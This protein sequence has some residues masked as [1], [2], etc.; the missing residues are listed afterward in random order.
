MITT[1]LIQSGPLRRAF[2]TSLIRQNVENKSTRE[3]DV[4]VRDW[5]S[6][7]TTTVSPRDQTDMID[8]SRLQLLD[9]TLPPFDNNVS[10]I[11][12]PPEPGTP[13][14]PGT[15]LTF[16]PPLVRT[17]DLFPD[18]TDTTYSSPAPFHRRMWA[19]G[20]FAFDPGNQLKFGQVIS[21]KST[22][23]DVQLK[24]WEKTREA[25]QV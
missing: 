18:G 15:E 5:I 6:K 4:R 9:L 1:R 2:T 17:S 14:N 20:A 11:P 10:G 25:R 19:G 3:A 23:E 13:T 12:P 21:Y 22:V 7:K 24:G 8:P 16:F